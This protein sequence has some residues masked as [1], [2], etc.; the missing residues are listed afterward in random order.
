M[1]TLTLVLKITLSSIFGY[2]TLNSFF[3]FHVTIKRTSFLAAVALVLVMIFFL[4]TDLLNEFL[5]VAG[6]IA[7]LYGIAE[8]I[9]RSKKNAGFL[10]FNIYR[11]DYQRVHEDLLQIAG[12]LGI[13]K[14]SICHEQK[15]PFL[16]VI[17]GA[18]PKSIHSLMKK[19]D[20]KYS[21]DP[22]RFTMYHYWFIIGLLTIITILWRF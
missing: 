10:M 20:G 18:D 7:I 11:K 19:L 15:K 17:K 2:L 9:L 22:K 3:H 16:I 13:R 1:I 6:S 12:Q 14:A 4:D 5:I 21:H 8:L